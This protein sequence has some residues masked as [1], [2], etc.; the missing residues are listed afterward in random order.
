MVLVG[1]VVAVLMLTDKNGPSTSSASQSHSHS[2]AAQSTAAST[3]PA[4]DSPSATGQSSTGAAAV[5]YEPGT[6]DL[7]QQ[8][9]TDLLGDTIV[10]DSITVNSDGSVS[11]ELTYFDNYSGEWTCAAAKPG[12]ATLSIATGA[13]D[14]ST[15]SDCTKD[16]T[17]TWYM[18][19]G[20][21][22]VG[23]EYFAA[24]PAGDGSWTFGFDSVTIEG[25]TEFQGT[26]SNI[27]IP[28]N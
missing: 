23:H 26:V 19:A 10:L 11:A 4:T 15:G 21:S 13:D 2:A 8:V 20:Q 1:A 27:Q 12:E 7:N 25:I 6:Y 16:P 18:S 5:S 3:D 17:K 28:T 9:A 22:A 14:P 24:P